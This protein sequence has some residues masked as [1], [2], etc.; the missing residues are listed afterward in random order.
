MDSSKL[1]ILGGVAL[2]GFLLYN[3][4]KKDRENSQVFVLQNSQ[5]QPRMLSQLDSEIKP[6][7]KEL[8][9]PKEATVYAT[10]T[11][12][13]VNSLIVKYPPL[14]MN[15]FIDN[16]NK[17]YNTNLTV[18]GDAT[19][20]FK[21]YAPKSATNT[22][23]NTGKGLVSAIKDSIYQITEIRESEIKV[24]NADKVFNDMQRGYSRWKS[25]FATVYSDL[26]NYFSKVLI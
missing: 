22:I 5:T 18:G 6:N 11:I 21:F 2:G 10:K 23:Q 26:K 14:T 9:T 20:G 1:L 25:E 19:L 13:D 4:S 3:K 15:Q 12:A 24:Q 16:Y 7:D 17:V 8:L